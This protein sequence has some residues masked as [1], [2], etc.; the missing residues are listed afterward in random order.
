MQ[1]HDGVEFNPSKPAT[2]IKQMI[3]DG[4]QGVLV[5][6]ETNGGDGLV[7]LINQQNGNIYEALRK[8]NSGSVDV[9]DLDFAY[10]ATKCY[11]ADV[12]NRLQGWTDLKGARTC[13]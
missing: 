3:I 6:Q 2:T 5:G 12:A 4:T 8:Y 9:N 11:V 13:A 1:S 10:S 7:Q